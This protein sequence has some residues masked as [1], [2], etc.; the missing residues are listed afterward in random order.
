[1]KGLT[2]PE[3][4][5]AI[6][7]FQ[8][9]MRLRDWTID[10]VIQDAQPDWAGTSEDTVRGS[11]LS[12]ASEKHAEIWLRP[13]VITAESVD[14]LRVLFH[15]LLH[16]LWTDAVIDDTTNVHVEHA[17]TRLAEVLM[18]AYRKGMN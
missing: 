6:R 10:L 3:A 1:M 9:Q 7:W 16:T 4:R 12:D 8:R 14:P 11:V 13:K 15:E 17:W 5:K 2:G 18:F